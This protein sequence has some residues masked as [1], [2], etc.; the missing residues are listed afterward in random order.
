MRSVA[1]VLVLLLCSCAYVDEHL[2]LVEVGMSPA[3][4][5]DAVGGPDA[6]KAAL[7]NKYGQKIDIWQYSNSRS[8]EEPYY[9][10]FVEGRLALWGTSPDW[11]RMADQF[12][13]PPR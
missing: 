6:V 3:G 12:A 13:S 11:Q 8:A 5:T 1:A 10:Y 4:L 2:D 7:I 9:F